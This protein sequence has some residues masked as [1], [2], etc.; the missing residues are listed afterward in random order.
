M[1]KLPPGAGLLAIAVIGLAVALVVARREAADLHRQ[2][3]VLSR[4]NADLRYQLKRT[5]A[6]VAAAQQA[7]TGLD[8]QLGDTKSR[9]TAAE[10]KT[11]GLDRELSAVRGSLSELEQR[12]SQLRLEIETL[13]TAASPS[14]ATS[15]TPSPASDARLAELQQQLVDLPARPLEQPPEPPVPEPAPAPSS[16]PPAPFSVVRVGSQQAF[17]IIDFGGL[18]GAAIGRRLAV[19]RGTTDLATVQISE[20]RPAF[21]VA[22]VLPGTLK[23]QLQPGDRVLTD[24]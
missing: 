23:G 16:V 4:Q 5:A 3:T 6:E 13:R 19:H 10:A 11:I 20:T 1:S 22:Q 17:V 12:E 15:S 9:A 18:H 21:S 7:A 24:P 2:L 8:T 14:G